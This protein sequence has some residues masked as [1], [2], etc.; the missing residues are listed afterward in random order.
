M[1]TYRVFDHRKSSGEAIRAYVQDA[2]E[3]KTDLELLEDHPVFCARFPDL[4]RKIRRVIRGVPRSSPPVVFWLW[5]PTG[6]GKT[7][8]VHDRESQLD[9]VSFQQ[10]GT[11]II[12]YNHA[13]AALIDDFRVAGVDISLLLRILDRY[14]ITVSVK[15]GEAQW[16]P[17]RIYVT[18]PHRPEGLFCVDE[19]PQVLGRFS[20]HFP[21]S[22]LIGYRFIQ[23][24]RRLTHIL[25][26]QSIQ[27]TALLAAVTTALRIHCRFQKK[28]ICSP[29]RRKLLKKWWKQLVQGA[30][31]VQRRL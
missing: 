12:G 19:A 18:S 9:D 14:H 23:L 31:Q 5:G 22:F 16:N 24:L 7:R 2:K 21:F 27:N 10:K 17:A 13:P 26:V 6:S 8:W 11:F 28:P 4:P 25:Q 30:V 29:K 15:G 3:G 1:H 20:K